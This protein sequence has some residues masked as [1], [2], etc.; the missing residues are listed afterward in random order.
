MIPAFAVSANERQTSYDYPIVPGTDEWS[1]LTT[2]DQMVQ[3]CQI[4]EDILETIPTASLVDSVLN[5]PLL[6]DMFLF[7]DFQQG[8]EVIYNQFNGIKELFT[9][10]D[11]GTVL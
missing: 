8:F 2:H 11:V 6:A 10:E 9:R 5:Y 7:N 1:T 4:P 3:S